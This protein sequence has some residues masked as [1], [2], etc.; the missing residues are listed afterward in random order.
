MTRSTP[1]L[2]TLAVLAVSS[3][4][5]AACGGDDDEPTTAATTATDTATATATTTASAKPT[6]SL[7]PVEKDGVLHIG[8]ILPE[9]GSLAFLGPP[10]FAGVKLG[11]E[12]VNAA[13]GVLGKPVKLTEGDSGD[14]TTDIA[15]QTVDRLLAANTDAI[16]GAASS[17]V[18]LTVIDKIVGSGVVQFSPANTSKQLSTYDDKG[19]YFRTAPSDILQ[20]QVL[21]ELIIADGNQTVGILALQD[22]YGEGLAQDLTK[23]LTEGGAQVVETVIYDPAASGFDAEVEKIKAKNPEAVVVIGFEESN[24][25]L[26]SMIEKG[27]GPKDKKV[28]GTDGNMGNALGEQFKSTPGALQGMKGTTPL[29]QLSKDFEAKLLKIDPKL[30]DFNYAGESYDAVVVIALAAEAAKTDAGV[31]FAKEIIKVTKGGTKCK[32][33]KECMDLV[34]KGT[35]V[36][37]DGVTGPIEFDDVGDPGQASYGIL[38]FQADNKLKTLKFEL[39]GA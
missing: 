27:I 38:E 35:D 1:L 9:T 19:L 8:T 6:P 18:S 20:G 37:Y 39:A 3:I 28:Y 5:L 32:A 23:T 13:G 24:K 22:P 2:R 30:K 26:T 34:R 16:I 31:D 14:A 36:D 11:I 29:S 4:A 21:G 12:E 33:V 25:I 17:G 15:N 10:E 7:N